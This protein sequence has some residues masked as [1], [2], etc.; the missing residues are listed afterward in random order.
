MTLMKRNTEDT[1]PFLNDWMTDFW[2]PSKFFDESFNKR[3]VL[4]SA[5]I[6]DYKDRYQ[7]D[8]AVPGMEKEDFDISIENGV[9][10]VRAEITLEEE[11]ES[12]N[13]TRKEFS[14]QSFSRSF[15]LPLDCDEESIRA[16][17]K[18]GILCF[19]I[20]KLRTRLERKQKKIDVE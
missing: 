13:Y 16:N 17:Y 6:I 9:L 20:G 10:I 19:T 15:N 8:L 12:E 3:C 18:N 4:P 5:N 1:F 11:S 14:C 7:I 2:S